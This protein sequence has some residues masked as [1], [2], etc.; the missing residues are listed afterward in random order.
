[1]GTLRKA[2]PGVRNWLIAKMDRVRVIL[3]KE[4]ASR[5]PK[6]KE[7]E[8]VFLTSH[9]PQAEEE[10]DQVDQGEAVFDVPHDT[11]FAEPEQPEQ[12]EQPTPKAEPKSALLTQG[13]PSR[14]SRT[15]TNKYGKTVVHWTR[16]PMKA[17]RKFL[18]ICTWTMM[19][20]NVAQESNP[21]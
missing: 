3:Q 16:S 20:S 2:K 1:M 11:V 12:K 9:Q 14:T 17:T 15:T 18:E 21:L 13:T 4:L 6:E 8:M 10:P 7:T 19:L 5:R